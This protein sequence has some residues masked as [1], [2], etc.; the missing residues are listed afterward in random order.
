MYH[1][2]E[3]KNRKDKRFRFSSLLECL[4]L[5]ALKVSDL[6]VRMKSCSG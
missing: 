1:F 2:A 4:F 6:A 5:I 3:D